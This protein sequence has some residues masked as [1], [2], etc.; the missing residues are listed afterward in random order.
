MN[1]L[2]S[3]IIPTYNRKSTLKRA[4]DSVLNQTYQN[5]EIVIVDDCSTDGTGEFINSY[6]DNRILYYKNEK[7]MGGAASRNV[8]LGYSHGEIIAF[9]DSDN[10]WKDEYLEKRLGVIAEGYDFTFG[11]IEI[12]EENGNCVVLPV[13]NASILNNFNELMDTILEH[14]VVDT[15]GVVM[16]RIC[17]ESCGGFS[18]NLKKYQDW[19]YFMKIL[20]SQK[21]NYYFCD[22]ILINN[23]RQSDSISYNT[24]TTWESL[25]YIFTNHKELY[26]KYNKLGAMIQKMFTV[27]YEGITVSDRLKQLDDYLLAEDI[28]N[29]FPFLA[30]L[31]N[32]YA[33]NINSLIE[34]RN[35]LLEENKKKEQFIK[36]LQIEQARKN[37][38]EEEN[39]KKE[40]YILE[41]QKKI[42]KLNEHGFLASL[43]K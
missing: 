20:G 16:K 12:I 34:K 10:E 25:L 5:F 40:E 21:F 42:D 28:K 31:V 13:E 4:I 9:L 43:K 3:V 7:N 22:D 24:G 6:S 29:I 35:L 2:V 8:G 18:N 17:Y 37:L 32:E 39:K 11:R 41:L 14:N 30:I 27:D 33:G 38:L 36:E 19:D 23:Y 1:E 15:N 26:C